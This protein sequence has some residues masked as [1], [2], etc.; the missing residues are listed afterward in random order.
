MVGTI[1]ASKLQALM[2]EPL[3]LPSCIGTIDASK[4]QALRFEPLRL[5]SF[6]AVAVGTIHASELQ[7]RLEPE[8][9]KLQA[10]MIGT[11]DASKLQALRLEPLR[12]PS[13]RP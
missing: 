6:K 13:F 5:P 12:L 11:I 7:L 4:L 3:R 9:S 10:L 1:D 2:L 8:G